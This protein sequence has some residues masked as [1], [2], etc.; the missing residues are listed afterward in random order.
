[1]PN[2]KQRI[3]DRQKEQNNLLVDNIERDPDGGV[4]TVKCWVCSTPVCGWVD[5]RTESVSS[6]NGEKVIT[7]R[8]RFRSLAN[9][10]KAHFTLDDGSN[11][12]PIVCKDCVKQINVQDCRK[13]LT[14]DI[15]LHE[16]DGISENF[17]EKML[18]R[19]VAEFKGEHVTTRRGA[20][21]AR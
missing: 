3:K 15:A 10:A 16:R 20:R 2:I 4:K 8:Q 5:E 13:F 1:M 9:Y 19:Q 14:R 17:L 21:N 6:V 18:D 11:Y 7:I 12:T